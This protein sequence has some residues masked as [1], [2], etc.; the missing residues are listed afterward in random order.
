MFARPLALALGVLFPLGNASAAEPWKPADGEHLHF[1]ILDGSKPAGDL[2]LRFSRPGD[3]LVVERKQTMT[4]SRMMIK[5][6]FVQTSTEHWASNRFTAIH[7]KTELTSTVK[8]EAKSLELSRTAD[9]MLSGQ[10]GADSLKLPADALPLSLWSRAGI[11]DGIYFDP[12]DGK[13]GKL[14]VKP[15]K[16]T[17]QPPPGTNADSCSGIEIAI[18]M[19][20]EKKP[21]RALIWLDPAGKVCAMRFFTALGT[22]DYA[23]LAD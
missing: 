2:W 17:E 7:S 8:D 18:T 1:K 14:A 9:G 19:A 10:S 12:S 15:G 22:L 5:A 20:A 4:I 3:E 13:T 23:P 21:S 16:V 6:A 11:R